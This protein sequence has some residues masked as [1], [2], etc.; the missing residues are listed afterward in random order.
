MKTTDSGMK[1]KLMK[2]AVYSY[3]SPYGVEVVDQYY[4]TINPSQLAAESKKSI[5]ALL[6]KYIGKMISTVLIR[7][8][9]T[10]CVICEV[11]CAA[12]NPVDTKWLYGDKLPLP[13]FPLV[14]KVLNG[15]MCGID[16]AGVVV[17][18]PDGCGF[19]PGDEVFGSIPPTKIVVGESGG[20]FAEVVRCPADCIHLKPENM[21]WEAA[22]AVPL[23]GLTVLQA[24]REAKLQA[25]QHVCVVGA[26]GGTGHVAVQLAKA[27]GARVTAICGHRNLEFVSQL[28]ADSI[29]AYDSKDDDKNEGGNENGDDYVVKKLG[30]V[31]AEHGAFDVVFDTVT[32][33]DPRDRNFNYERRMKARSSRQ[34]MSQV[35]LLHERS[36]Y[37]SLGGDSMDWILA[38]LKRFLGVDLFPRGRMLFWVRLAGNGGVCGGDLS[39]LKTLCEQRRLAVHVNSIHPLT[40]QGM[41]RAFQLQ[42]SRHVVGKIVIRVNA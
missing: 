5:I 24:F 35:R 7:P 34:S 8:I 16:F 3:T 17:E 1:P 18:A 6:F 25:N 37:I 2:A 4:P 12:V 40:S 31:C 13:F 30:Q 10:K 14:K 23:V 11:K 29:I 41:Q 22:S 19:S 27:M 28:G 33:Q 20:S 15:R 26:S 21:S 32:S 39:I 36:T 9:V 42:L 38:H